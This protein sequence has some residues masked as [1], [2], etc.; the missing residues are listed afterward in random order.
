MKQRRRAVQA[1]EWL[2]NGSCSSVV[3][4]LPS[5]HKCNVYYIIRNVHY[6]FVYIYIYRE[7]ERAGRT[8]W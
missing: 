6:I 8:T 7:R 1:P 5:M 4:I 2:L 3:E